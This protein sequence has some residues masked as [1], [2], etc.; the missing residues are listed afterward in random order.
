MS[1]PPF[2]RPKMA[3][4]FGLVQCVLAQILCGGDEIVEDVLLVGLHAGLVPRTAVLPA[5]AQI[6]DRVDAAH[7]YPRRDDGRESRSN[8]RC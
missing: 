3:R 2:E 6:G 1:S 4:R 7:L 5:A 8:G